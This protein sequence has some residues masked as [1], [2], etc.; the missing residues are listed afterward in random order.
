MARAPLVR[1]GPALHARGVRSPERSMLRPNSV[2]YVK[3]LF[4]WSVF[5][6]RFLTIFSCTI[7]WLLI[8]APL[9]AGLSDI[10]IHV[11]PKQTD[12]SGIKT[13]NGG[14]AYKSKE[15]WAY[16]VT[17]E[18]KSFKPLDNL[19]VRYVIFVQRE[20]FGTKA[21]PS[22][23]KEHGS[24]TVETLKPHEIKAVTTNSI[25]LNMTGLDGHYYFPSGG[26]RKA[27]DSLAGCWVRIYQAGQQ[28]GEYANPS[29]LLRE[30]WE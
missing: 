27:Q 1:A 24:V 15:H 8:V 29:T 6:K 18:N 5:M 30:K 10:E 26:N 9:N 20:Q 22:V 4:C 7:A 14:S 13:V 2:L 16:D 19:E 3:V 11:Q 28:V 17:L 12:Q 25:E 21:A 23:Q